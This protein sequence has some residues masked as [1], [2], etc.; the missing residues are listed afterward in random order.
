MDRTQLK[1]GARISLAGAAILAVSALVLGQAA[2]GQQAP[3]GN[4]GTVKVDG[5]AFD[6]HPNNEPHVGCVFQI[7]FENYDEVEGNSA[8]VTFR[9]VP[10]TRG[11]VLV[12]ADE[13]DIS[14]GSGS[15]TYDLTDELAAS[16]VGP[17]PRQGFHIRLDIEADGSIG[18]AKKHKVF[19]VE[20]EGV[21]GTTT[22][23]T[24]KATTTTT[25]KDTTTTTA[26]DTTTTSAKETTTTTA[27][28][29]T[30]TVKGGET[31]TTAKPAGV[32]AAPPSPP[33]AAG[34]LPVTGV[35]ALPL[36]AGGLAL[37][38]LGL[39]L[40]ARRAGLT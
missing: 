19:W 8:T 6:D 14:G 2:S 29:T 20:C 9:L 26:K 21:P 17:H 5:V 7:D 1:W 34:Q 15:R 16:G 40:M 18:A 36:A 38:G 37:L 11:P 33:G 31:T 27:M 35:P 3:P 12:D 32:P 25:A 39:G 24:M 23:T 30:T 10:P 13:V 28:G 22:S 4:N